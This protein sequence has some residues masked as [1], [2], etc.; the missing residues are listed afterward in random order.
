M[1]MHMY[2]IVGY[3]L[4]V[5]SLAVIPI[6]YDIHRSHCF[7]DK[8]IE[9]LGYNPNNK[10]KIE[11]E[12]DNV[13]NNE[14]SKLNVSERKYMIEALMRAPRGVQG[15]ARTIIALTVMVVLGL[16]IFHIMVFTTN[17]GNSELVNSILSMLA[18]TLAA[19]TGFYFGG[20]ATKEGA[21][22]AQ[23]DMNKTNSGKNNNSDKV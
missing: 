12:Q 6:T 19:I 11:M 9:A 17:P 3:L 23:N 5:A 20:R 21:S 7:R 16:S 14:Q 1:V 4:I 13:I 15:L 8:C 2:E 10:K 18:A 22:I